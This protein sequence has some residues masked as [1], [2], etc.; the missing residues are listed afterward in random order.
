MRLVIED[1]SKLGTGVLKG[2]IPQR[3]KA[4]AYIDGKLQIHEEIKPC[5][6]S[7]DPKN[8]FP[9]GSCGEDIQNGGFH[10]ER[11]FVTYS[12]LASLRGG[13]YIDKQIDEALME[14]PHAAIRKFDENTTLGGL[15]ERKTEEM[16]E[17]WYFYGNLEKEDLEAAGVDF[18]DDEPIPNIPVHLA[19]VNNRVIKADRN[20][21]DTGEFPYDYMVWQRRRN[22]PWGLGVAR[23]IR[24]PQRVVVGAARNLMDNAGLAGGPMWVFLQGIIEPIDGIY[25]IRP[26][27]GWM[28]SDEADFRAVQDAISFIEMPMMQVELTAIIQLGLKMAEDVTGLPMLM[29]GQQGAAPD[30]VGGMQMLNNNAS[31]VLRRIARLFDDNVTEPHITRYYTYLLQHGEDIEKGEFVIDARG[32]SAL[33]ER[34]I[35]NQAIGEMANIVKDPVFKLDPAKWMAEYLKSQRLDPKRFEYDDDKW[36]QIVEQMSQP[37]ADSRLEV[38]QLTAQVQQA[39]EQLKSQTKL[40]DT[41]MKL[42]TETGMQAQQHAHEER[43]NQMELQFKAMFKELELENEQLR[44]LGKKEISL[45]DIKARLADT[46]MKLNTQKELSKAG[47]GGETVKPAAEPKGRAP[48]GESFTK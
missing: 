46:V 26:R 9:D 8:C 12:K 41:G 34:D 47:L 7:I 6:F 38:A 17:I 13:D 48:D 14:G 23:Q 11:D 39:I 42:E 3:K 36:Q 27:K 21:L 35:Q 28:A 45:G 44:A 40:Q 29:Q 10:W 5:S 18:P 25:D 43:Q 24:T 37:P 4:V 22:V 2:P 33:I 16:F 30:T 1:T 32:S 20:H 19:L 15:V 31:T